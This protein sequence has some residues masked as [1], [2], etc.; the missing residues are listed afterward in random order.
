MKVEIKKLE[1][2]IIWGDERQGFEM[3]AEREDD[4]AEY[5]LFTGEPE[6]MIF[7]RRLYGPKAIKEMIEMAHAAG[8]AGEPLIIR[9]EVVD[10]L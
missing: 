2:E 4:K 5:E 7:G 3:S 9:E 1:T 8:K 10:E 6:D